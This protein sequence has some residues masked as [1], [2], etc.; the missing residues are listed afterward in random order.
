MKSDNASRAMSSQ[1][2][3]ALREYALLRWRAPQ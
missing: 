2:D 1:F 3:Q